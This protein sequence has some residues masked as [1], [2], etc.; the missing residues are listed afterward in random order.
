MPARVS[1]QVLQQHAQ[2][3]ILKHI[4]GL[5]DIQDDQ[6][7][8]SQQIIERKNLFERR[9]KE[10]HEK[11]GFEAPKDKT[12]AKIKK[13]AILEPIADKTPEAF[14]QKMSRNSTLNF[15]DSQANYSALFEDYQEPKEDLRG[16]HD[17]STELDIK[18]NFPKP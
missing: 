16:H 8:P 10:W 1:I 4:F 18:D 9:L 6:E 3:D 14:R 17:Q 5:E 7:R 11:P 13:G 2:S 15:C 12:P